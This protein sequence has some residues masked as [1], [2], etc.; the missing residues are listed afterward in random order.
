VPLSKKKGKS[1]A[2]LKDMLEIVVRSLVA[3]IL[4]KVL[5]AI[6]AALDPNLI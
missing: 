4:E 6:V 1:W 3:N 5:E 2:R